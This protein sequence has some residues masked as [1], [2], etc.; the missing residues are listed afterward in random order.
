MVKQEK[1]N[2]KT[3]IR[4]LEKRNI[5]QIENNHIKHVNE[6]HPRLLF[7]LEM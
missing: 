6:F 1:F 4:D 2:L 3:F 7:L 5:T